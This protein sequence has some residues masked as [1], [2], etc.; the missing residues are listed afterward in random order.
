MNPII[1]GSRDTAYRDPA[2][3]YHN[4]TYHLFFT[5]GI[6]EDGYMYNFV[7]KS[8]STDLIHWSAPVVLTP[9]DRTLNYCSPGNIIP[10]GD[11]YALCLT[12]YPLRTPYRDGF[13]ADDTARLYLM[14][15]EDFE[16]FTEPVL[17]RAK[18]DS[19]AR[20]MGRMIDPFILEDKD[21]P[22]KY[23]LFFKQNGV[24]ISC[25]HDLEHWTYERHIEG[26]ENAC[27]LIRDGQ[28]FLIHSPENGIGFK[29][30]HNLIDWTDCGCT[31]LDQAKWDWA[32]GRLTAGFA[33]E[34]RGMTQHRYLMFFHDSKKD[35]FPE[36]HGEASLGLVFT[37]DFRTFYENA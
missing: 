30:S 7:A 4:G 25:S 22:G 33:M 9:K 15:T 31:V 37:D 29:T 18:G 11:R 1:R 35:A 2:C 23:W 28:Y 3:Y 21:E 16:H 34:S 13:W 14:Y 17:I 27:V 10:A 6:K 19:T 5:K 32:G 8:T 12:S 20:E 24:S 36:T 26:G